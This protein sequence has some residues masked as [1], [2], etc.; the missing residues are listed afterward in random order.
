MGGVGEF[1]RPPCGKNRCAVR[2]RHRCRTIRTLPCAGR[3]AWGCTRVLS[4]SE[5]RA[6]VRGGSAATAHASWPS[7]FWRS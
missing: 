3:I 1:A 6:A 2:P 5:R 4:G 7:D